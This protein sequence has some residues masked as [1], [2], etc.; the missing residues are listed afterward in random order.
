MGRLEGQV[1][2]ISGVA[3]GQGRSHAVRLAEEGAGIIGFDICKDIDSV[4]YPLATASD[5]DETIKLVEATGRRIVARQ[6]DVRDAD[7][8]RSV[9]N[10]G[11]AEFGH[12]DIVLA[13]A[14]ALFGQ[15]LPDSEWARVMQAWQDSIDV[16]MTGVIN[17]VGVA[18]PALLSQGTGGSIVITS[19]TAGLKSMT[20][21]ADSAAAAFSVIGYNA[22][23]HGVIGVMRAL[24][25]ALAHANVRVNTVHPTAV[26]T[27]F[28]VNDYFDAMFQQ[29]AGNVTWQNAM[30]VDMVEAVDVSN[31][32]VWLC[33]EEA[34]Y[35]TGITLPV[36]A[37][38]MIR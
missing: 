2:F 23:K 38:F 15:S 5:L 8:V 6:A 26:N 10:D 35:V 13:N 36:D 37:G 20:G 18:V 9:F 14:G 17:T 29:N 7:A 22:A 1:A 33:S 34:R 21:P 30:P 3:R 31:A 19:S 24:A 28:I 25:G 16:M 4:P 12:I 27:P 11:L 32:I